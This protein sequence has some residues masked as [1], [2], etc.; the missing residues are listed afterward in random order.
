MS[1][2]SNYIVCIK[3]IILIIFGG[4]GGGDI[5]PETNNGVFVLVNEIPL[6]NLKTNLPYCNTFRYTLK[7]RYVY[8]ICKIKLTKVRIS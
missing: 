3:V 8:D 5:E 7:S 4:G 6:F 2:Y 1:F